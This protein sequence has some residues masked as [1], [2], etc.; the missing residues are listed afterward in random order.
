MQEGRR[1]SLFYLI[2]S[3]IKRV[4]SL[5]IKAPCMQWRQNSFTPFISCATY[6]KRH[7][8]VLIQLWITKKVCTQV[9]VPGAAKLSRLLIAVTV[10]NMGFRIWCFSR[11]HAAFM[12]SWKNKTIMPQNQ[13]FL[14]LWH[15]WNPINFIIKILDMA[16]ITRKVL[17][18]EYLELKNF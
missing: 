9:R 8:M 1:Y 18:F 12:C 6:P 4:W 14:K 5:I 3:N 15:I 16:K 17:K 7:G 2:I 13:D 11:H 10:T